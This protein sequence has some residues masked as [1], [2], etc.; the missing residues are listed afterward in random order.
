MLWNFWCSEVCVLCVPC[1]YVCVCVVDYIHMCAGMCI[2]CDLCVQVC[3]CVFSLGTGVYVCVCVCVCA[4][5]FH[6][7]RCICYGLHVQGYVCVCALMSACAHMH[8]GLWVYR[9]LCILYVLCVQVC[10]S[11]VCS[12]C[13]CVPGLWISCVGQHSGVY[14]GHS[15]CVS[16][17]Y[18]PPVTNPKI[19]RALLAGW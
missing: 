6:V 15:T 4:V 3:V 17:A 19:I 7:H 5:F 12:L 18:S 10:G 16:I 8:Y 14:R 2:C 13:M 11:T 1:A 9:C